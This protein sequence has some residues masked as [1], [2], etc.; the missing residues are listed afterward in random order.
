[1][2]EKNVKTAEPKRFLIHNMTRARETLSRRI[3][4][5]RE[6]LRTVLVL[7]AGEVRVMRN[8]PVLATESTIRKLHAELT[9]RIQIGAAKVTTA[10]GKPV[11]IRSLKPTGP[12]PVKKDPK[13]EPP[14]DSVANDIPA[15]GPI[16]RAEGMA[17]QGAEV[18]VPKVGERAI[19]DGAPAPESLSPV[20]PTPEPEPP[21]SESEEESEEESGGEEPSED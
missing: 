7:G 5:P 20:A 21:T 13:P 10:D 19:P 16:P 1:M 15:G 11:D 14:K 12:V 8:R 2:P 18:P 17:P 9:A 4:V 3:A 6:R